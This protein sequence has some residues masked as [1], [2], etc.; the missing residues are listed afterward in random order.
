MQR[1]KR[2]EER[3]RVDRY[4]WVHYVVQVVVCA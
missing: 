3:N 1:V 4:L 2:W